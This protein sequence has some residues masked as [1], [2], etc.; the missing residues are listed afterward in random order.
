VEYTTIGRAERNSHRNIARELKNARRGKFEP[1]VG[2]LEDVVARWAKGNARTLVLSSETF[3]ECKPREIRQLR[4][5]FAG[6]DEK[7]RILF[8]IRDLLELL[9]SIF[10]QQ[11]R[12]GFTSQRFDEFFEKMMRHPRTDFFATAEQWAD[13]F[14]WDAMRVRALDSRNLV[15]G[16]LLEEIV[17]TLQIEEGDL[18]LLRTKSRNASTGW[19]SLVAVQALVENR[20][21][22]PGAH[23]L[24]AMPRPDDQDR[25]LGRMAMRVAA[26]RGWDKDKGRYFTRE[27]AMQCWEKFRATVE[28]INMHTREQ[29]PSPLSLDERNFVEREFEPDVRHIPTDELRTFYDEL[30]QESKKSKQTSG[31][32]SNR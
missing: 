26:R 12:H 17:A 16:S 14:G 15:N 27:Q 13:V 23:P 4:R 3:E 18:R 20:H 31:R 6:L 24:L 32:L 9:P 2:T 21:G 28:K 30:W 29:I 1:D 19:K 5:A 11:C 7:F 22:L 8:V 25:P 10:D